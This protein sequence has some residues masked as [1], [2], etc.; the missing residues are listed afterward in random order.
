ML[1]NI[2]YSASGSVLSLRSRVVKTDQSEQFHKIAL[3]KCMLLTRLERVW[4]GVNNTH[5]YGV[6]VSV[7]C[8]GQ[9]FTNRPIRAVP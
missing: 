4:V 9:G 2:K 1:I 8:E 6:C 7:K 3:R 5:I